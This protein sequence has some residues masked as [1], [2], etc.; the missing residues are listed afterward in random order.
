MHR[1][2]IRAYL[3][4][5][6]VVYTESHE[7]RG[8]YDLDLPNNKLVTVSTSA[9]TLNTP[10]GIAIGN[11]KG[12]SGVFYSSYSDSDIWFFEST[13]TCEQSGSC[14]VVKVAGT[15]DAGITDGSLTTATFVDPSRMLYM[16]DFNVLLIAD[17][18]NGYLRYISFDSS[19]V[20]TMKTSAGVKLQLVGY[21]A[22]DNNPEL[23]IKRHGNYL[24]ASDT[25]FVYN[26][27]GDDGTLER[28]FHFGVVKK[29]TALAQWQ[30][31]MGYLSTNKVFITSI[32]VDN[33]RHQLYVSYTFAR[34][35]L[36]VL[37]LEVTS[38][39]DVRILSSDGV[40]YNIPLTYPRPV[41]GKL[42]SSNPAEVAVVTF[43]IHMHYDQTDDV[44]YWLEVYPTSVSASYAMGA[45][46][47]R[48]LKFSTG[49]IDYYAGDTATYRDGLGRVVGYIDGPSNVAR[50]RY[51]V[52]M[53]FLSSSGPYGLGPV[54]YVCDYGNGA[55]RKVSTIVNTP[56]PT[57]APSVS[58]RPTFAPTYSQRP[59]PFPSRAPTA[60]P[61]V[62]PSYAPSVAPSSSA[63]S[64]S[65]PSVTPTSSAPTPLPSA[66]WQPTL[67][68]EPTAGPTA[69]DGD[70]LEILLLDEFGDG[71]GGLKLYAN[72][73]GWR[74]AEAKKPHI[75]LKDGSDPDIVSV[76]YSKAPTA[77]H[78][79]LTFK[80][81]A[82][83]H[84]DRFH[85]RGLYVLEIGAPP[86]Q[87]APCDWEVLWQVSSM[88]QNYNDVRTGGR[89]TRMEFEFTGDGVFELRKEDR[90]LPH[91]DQC[92]RCDHPPPNLARAPPLP[93]T[94]A[95]PDLS[96]RDPPPPKLHPVPFVLHDS[97]GD[98]WFT[99]ELGA[100]YAITDH[101][102]TKLLSSG[103]VCGQLLKE[104]C[105][106]KLPDG[107]YYFR[108]G[109]AGDSDSSQI[110]WTFCSAHGTAQQELS[111]A[112]FDGKCIPGHHRDAM[113][114]IGT[115][116]RT[117][118]VM[119]GE[120]LLDNTF[121]PELS[122]V[123]TRVFESAIA[124]VLRVDS[125]AVFITEACVTSPGRLCS[126]SDDDHSYDTSTSVDPSSRELSATFL[127]DIAFVVNVVVEDYAM[128]GSQY[129]DAM[130]L[131]QNKKK[132]LDSSFV[133]Q[134]LEKTI[135]E[136]AQRTPGSLLGFVQTQH[137]VPLKKIALRY[138][139][140]SFSTAPTPAPASGSLAAAIKHVI[141]DETVRQEE[142]VLLPLS[143]V[144]VSLLVVYVLKRRGVANNQ[145]QTNED[146]SAWKNIVLHSEQDKV[147]VD[148]SSTPVPKQ[149][150]ATDCDEGDVYQCPYDFDDLRVLPYVQP[151]YHQR[152]EEN[153]FLSKSGHSTGLYD[154]NEH[155]VRNFISMGRQTGEHSV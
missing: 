124:S 56:Q 57:P 123:D 31:N 25:K 29:Y 86:H 72:H 117:T 145:L 94:P 39:G 63:P 41:N 130:S 64:S 96:P 142:L 58:L 38:V 43:P 73:S 147:I 99:S 15:S 66:S 49:M 128:V 12:K 100:K 35:A 55:I 19:L 68:M 47:V 51:P 71:W 144:I 150:P 62:P 54:M 84:E 13:P 110:A 8:L 79:P 37:P 61:I 76:S 153:S 132:L 118:I 74:S 102:K 17:R 119:R 10:M 78:N 111:F 149:S 33:T 26:I 83:L 20:G 87:E 154:I 101:T 53:A 23:D 34:S 120:L 28:S 18:A 1:Q 90:P 48:R 52:T 7:A 139:F 45:V 141:I 59:T 3:L 103:T 133:G 80:I 97:G 5:L 36:V 44:L 98:G 143:I 121:S 32:A 109:G 148:T 116:E 69:L 92:T 11:F 9:K 46:A 81:C 126:S 2:S 22:S 82:S 107:D 4:C 108:V 88:S 42:T 89:H 27:T 50:F 129:H 6:L 40:L 136:E 135:R 140:D 125:S 134:T 77:T 21:Q 151:R 155:I 65:A 104:D 138:G 60:A 16:E 85:D 112:I 93:Q 75:A 127:L 91:P 106:V 137:I 24:Y 131:F 114:L 67:G 113:S 115:V 95:V 146:D 122:A 14:V 152:Q 105:E 70:C 30:I